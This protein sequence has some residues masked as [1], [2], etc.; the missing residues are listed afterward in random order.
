MSNILQAPQV[1]AAVNFTGANTVGPQLTINLPTVLLT[2]SKAIGVINDDW[3]EVEVDGEVLG[4]ITTGSYGTI[5][6]TG[7][8]TSPNITNYYIGKGA[9]LVTPSGSAQFNVGMVSK[10]EITPKPEILKHYATNLGTKFLDL[11]IVKVKEL[12]LNM[13][14]DEFTLA[15]L[16]IALLAQ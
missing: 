9:V 11:A 16:N 13:T 3:G 8:A 2:T 5:T 6:E 1:I 10:F 4:N 14:L 7:G 12:A 15:N